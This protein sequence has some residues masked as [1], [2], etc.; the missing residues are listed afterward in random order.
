M[1]CS[2]FKVK[3][4]CLSESNRKEQQGR[5]DS[6]GI[7]TREG[8]L[9]KGCVGALGVYGNHT[10]ATEEREWLTQSWQETR[11]LTT[12]DFSGSGAILFY[13]GAVSHMRLLVFELKLI[14]IT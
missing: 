6:K 14:K 7:V 11:E 2:S 12:K 4:A 1:Y 10:Q 13:M 9:R 8:L 5:G 3:T